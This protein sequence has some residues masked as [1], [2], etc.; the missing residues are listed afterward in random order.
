MYCHSRAGH[1]FG[2]EE[3]EGREVWDC[4]IEVSDTE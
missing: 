3:G 4:S 2:G 1:T